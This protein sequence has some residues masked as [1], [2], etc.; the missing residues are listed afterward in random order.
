[1]NLLPTGDGSTQVLVRPDQTSPSDKAGG[2]G[3]RIPFTMSRQHLYY[4]SAEWQGG[5]QV[6]LDEFA[7]GNYVRFDSDDP[8]DIVH[9]L[10]EDENEN[11]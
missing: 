6:A 3:I 10:H 11:E 8:E 5:E 2:G 1:M 9:W 4:W 7:S